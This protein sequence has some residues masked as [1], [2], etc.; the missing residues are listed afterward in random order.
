[1]AHTGLYGRVVPTNRM[2]VLLVK[3][4]SSVFGKVVE[5]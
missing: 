1:M 5:H 4:T 3:Q 2:H